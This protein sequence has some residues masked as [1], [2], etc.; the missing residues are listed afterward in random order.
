M[1]FQPLANADMMK[2][3]GRG[4]DSLNSIV[5]LSRT[6]I[7]LT[8]LNRIERGMEMPVGGLADAVVGGL[9]VVGGELG[10]VVELHVLAQVER[11][12]LAVLGD[13]PAMG[14][15]GDDGL[16][17]VARI[18]ANEIVEHAA[19]AAEAVD[20]ARLV[21]VEMRRP[22]GDAVAQHAA[23]LG[24]GLGRGELKLG[25]VELVRHLSQREI[26]AQAVG[27]GH[28]GGAALQA[29]LQDLTAI[30]MR[31]LRALTSHAV[32][33]TLCIF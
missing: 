25:A 5:C 28:R 27:R 18:A 33:S 4:W 14:E 21:H 22:R 23:A 19:L 16:A 29:S 6:L 7:S 32:S 13:L 15:I 31:A 12:G 30:P 11:V 3:A 9:H 8:E 20:R 26:G 10:A 2:L 17:A 1:T 24:V